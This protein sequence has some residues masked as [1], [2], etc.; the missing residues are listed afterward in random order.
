MQ[1]LCNVFAV[2]AALALLSGCVAQPRPMY[3]WGAYQNQVNAHFKNTA[4]PEQ[5]IAALQK[6]LPK[7]PAIFTAPPGYHAHLGLLYGETGRMDEMQVEFE[8]EKQ[9]FPESAPFMDF[10]LNKLNKSKSK[11]VGAL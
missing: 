7:A 1:P 5:Q 10:M 9:L 6:S 4:S 8:T 3:T 11:K 2:A